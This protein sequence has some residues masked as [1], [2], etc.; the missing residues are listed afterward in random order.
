LRSL[1]RIAAILLMGILF[2]NWYG[3]RL[4]TSWLEVRADHQ[5]EAR[6]DENSYDESQL[7]SIK[8]PSTHLSYYNSSSRFERVDGQ[9]E[10]GGVRYKYVARR[11]FNDSLELRCI[12]NQAAMRL[13]TVKNE[14][15]KG[16]NDIQQEN[17]PSKKSD[18]HSGSSRNFSSTDYYTVGDLFVLGNL[19]FTRLQK[20]PDRAVVAIISSLL[21]T[22]EQPPDPSS[23]HC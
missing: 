2:F 10:I 4:L 16:A 17:S 6:L 21:A 1:R 15:F 23:F 3:Y 9:I 13:A 14:F 5:L 7:I 12:P 19:Y 20:S 22:D 8:V 18:S 11:L